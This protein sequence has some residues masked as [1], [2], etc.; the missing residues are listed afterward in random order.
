MKKIVI[1]V[2]G[3]VG[4]RMKS[5]IPKQFIPICNKPVLM[6]TMYRFYEYDKQIEFRIVLPNELFPSWNN[7]CKQYNLTIPYKLFPGGITRFYSVK[8]GL[9]DIPPQS[10]IAVHDAVRPLVSIQTIKNCFDLAKDSGSAVPVMQL[11][12]SIREICEKNSIARFRDNYRLV[13]TPQVFKSEILLQSYSTEY[14]DSFTDD[15]SVVEYSGFPIYLTDGNVE[16]I[17]ITTPVDLLIGET[18]LKNNL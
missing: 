7:L 10:L 8:N 15:A 17:K 12:E 4:K 11:N 2:A 6:H 18:L 16:N 14:I 5:D 3:G 13:Q 1:L 9:D